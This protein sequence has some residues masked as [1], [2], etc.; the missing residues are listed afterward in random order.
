MVAYDFIF[1]LH[2]TK[3]CVSSALDINQVAKI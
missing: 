1:I 2:A 3:G